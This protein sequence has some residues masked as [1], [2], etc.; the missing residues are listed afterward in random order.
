MYRPFCCLAFVASLAAAFTLPH[1]PQRASSRSTLSA[2]A[3]KPQT[4]MPALTI[5][6]VAFVQAAALAP[7]MA[8][9]PASAFSSDY[10]PALLVL[11]HSVPYCLC[12]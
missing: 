1:G 7:V 9:A 4:E 12:L 3:V 6:K 11:I 5:D 8:A 2:Q 10:L